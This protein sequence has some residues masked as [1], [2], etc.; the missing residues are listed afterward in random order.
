MDPTLGLAHTHAETKQYLCQRPTRH[1]PVRADI[2]NLLD[3]QTL[4]VPCLQSSWLGSWG[5]GPTMHVAVFFILEVL[6]ITLVQD[7]QL[8]APSVVKPSALERQP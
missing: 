2:L 3:H 8:I 1:S 7:N 4:H 5:L 6:Y